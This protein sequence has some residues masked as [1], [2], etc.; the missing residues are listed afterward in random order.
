MQMFQEEEEGCLLRP[1][2][3]TGRAAAGR[4]TGDSAWARQGS[5]AGES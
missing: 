4:K 5:K 3:A 2:G 1:G